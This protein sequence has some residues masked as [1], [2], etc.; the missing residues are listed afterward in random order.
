M[1]YT[2]HF[3]ENALLWVDVL[4][5]N[6]FDDLEKNS[7]VSAM[8]EIY[9]YAIGVVAYLGE[10]DADSDLIFRT[11]THEPKS[12]LI[13]DGVLVGLEDQHFCFQQLFSRPYWRR[14]WTV[15][16]R[17][18][19]RR[20]LIL[21]GDQLAPWESLK[22]KFAAVEAGLKHKSGEK[23]HPQYQLPKL[24]TGLVSV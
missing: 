10:D 24:P 13:V 14:L 21:C 2:E 11:L 20:L 19:A 18:F 16:E 5:I 22:E 17:K 15:Q 23:S 9:L 8:A 3:D 4:C 6:Q 1:S 7:Q 12:P